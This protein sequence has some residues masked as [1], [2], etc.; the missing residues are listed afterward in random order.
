MNDTDRRNKLIAL[1]LAVFVIGV[2]ATSIFIMANRTVDTAKLDSATA[3]IKSAQPAKKKNLDTQ[4]FAQSGNCMIVAA[5]SQGAPAADQQAEY[6][7]TCEESGKQVVKLGP[8]SSFSVLDMTWAGVPAA[9]QAKATG[10][11]ETQIKA[12]QQRIADGRYFAEQTNYGVIGAPAIIGTQ[13]FVDA[14]MDGGSSSEGTFASLLAQHF[15]NINLGYHDDGTTTRVKDPAQQVASVSFA[16]VKYDL[17]PGYTT[18]IYTADMTITS[19][20]GQKTARRITVT[21]TFD[22]NA[23]VMANIS[24]ITLANAD[25]SAPV[26]LY[27]AANGISIPQLS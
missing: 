2:V 24:S 26:T 3:A 17:A 5:V 25:G 18:S 1:A 14:G 15:A 4:I 12:I 27:D 13:Q 16:N 6:Y 10:Q 22:P 7:I 19:G 8:A 11:S 21:E 9:L 20:T 23:A